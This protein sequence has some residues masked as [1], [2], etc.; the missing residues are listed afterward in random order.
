M[1]L[2]RTNEAYTLAF[3]QL[4]VGPLGGDATKGLAFVFDINDASLYGAASPA[5]TREAL[6]TFLSNLDVTATPGTV[7][8]SNAAWSP[9]RQRSVLQQIPE[10]GL[11]DIRKRLRMGKSTR[12]PGV[13]VTGGELFQARMRNGLPYFVLDSTHALT[14]FVP[15]NDTTVQSLLE[16]AGQTVLTE[17]PWT[18]WQ[19][20]DLYLHS[21]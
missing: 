17:H 16:M 20:C 21:P 5:T 8:I 9:Y 3:G 19:S 2:S 12:P 18:L 1:T 11:L 14:Y 6:V 4:S 15:F 10:I 7:A 13:K